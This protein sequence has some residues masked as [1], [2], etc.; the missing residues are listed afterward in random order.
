MT[1]EPE[2][3]DF[4]HIPDHVGRMPVMRK[5]YGKLDQITLKKVLCPGG[6]F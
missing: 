1:L 5:P 2:D 4:L 6:N 3:S